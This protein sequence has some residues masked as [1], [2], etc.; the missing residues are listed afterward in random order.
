MMVVYKPTQDIC[1]CDSGD[2]SGANLAH[3]FAQTTVDI[4]RNILQGT[5]TLEP[6]I[7][8][9][10]DLRPEGKDGPLVRSLESCEHYY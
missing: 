6:K 10:L 7:M 3:R 4:L 9:D 5:L 1:G 8:V 2:D